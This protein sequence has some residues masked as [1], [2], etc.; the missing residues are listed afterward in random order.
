M[1]SVGPSISTRTASGATPG[2]AAMI[3]SS[4]LGLEHVDRRLPAGAFA[5]GLEE[6]AMQLLGLLEEGAGLGPHLV[7][8]VTHHANLNAAIVAT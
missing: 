8:R 5:R 2:R 7:F 6:L 4:A 1:T 3:H